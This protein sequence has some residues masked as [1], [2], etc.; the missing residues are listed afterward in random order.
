[1]RFLIS[2]GGHI[3]HMWRNLHAASGLRMFISPGRGQDRYLSISYRASRRFFVCAGNFCL[4]CVCW[5]VRSLCWLDIENPPPRIIYSWI[6]RVA[7]KRCGPADA[8]CWKISQE[9]KRHRRLCKT[10][11]RT[12]YMAARHLKLVKFASYLI[13]AGAPLTKHTESTTKAAFR[14]PLCF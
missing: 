14:R 4:A 1:M 13:D 3:C 11:A 5:P 2:Q 12:K 8:R 9:P 6:I 10:R 7:S